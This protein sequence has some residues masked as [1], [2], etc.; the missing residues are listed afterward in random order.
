MTPN[1]STIRLFSLTFF[2]FL[3]L[4]LNTASVYA[5][6]DDSHIRAV[7]ASVA[8]CGDGTTW[9]TAYRYLQDALAYAS[10]HSEINQI[11]VV[12]ATYYPDQDCPNPDGTGLRQSTFLLDFNNIRP[13]GGFEGTETLPEERD[14][15]ENI[16]V[17]SGEIT[18]PLEDVCGE[19]NGPC[20]EAHE[21]PGCE[22]AACCATV[23]DPVHGDSFCCLV[24]WDQACADAAMEL[25]TGG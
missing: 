8:N 3:A 25:C 5:Q 9:N 24:R 14:P 21:N 15:A 6:F 1:M 19:G 20:L 13:L 4:S 17:L 16:T 23:C 10:T 12:T 11:W 2:V 18:F 22:D 7:D